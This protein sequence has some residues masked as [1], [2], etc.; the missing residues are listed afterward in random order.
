MSIRFYDFNG[1]SVLIKNPLI[2]T[3]WKEDLLEYTAGDTIENYFEIENISGATISNFKI[4]VHPDISIWYFNNFVTLLSNL[5]M[6]AKIIAINRIFDTYFEILMVKS[7]KVIDVRGE[8]DRIIIISQNT[9]QDQILDGL[10]LYFSSGII[11]G[12]NFGFM[13]SK[14]H[15]N[16]KI[17]KDLFGLPETYYKT[18]DYNIFANGTKIK[19]WI[20]VTLPSDWDSHEN[21]F[22]V[23]LDTFKDNNISLDNDLRYC[24]RNIFS[25]FWIPFHANVLNLSINDLPFTIGG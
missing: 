3:T 17:A 23:K 18:L 5:P 22:M 14:G 15:F 9:M 21:P 24:I 7:D 12:D 25:N 8:Q 6:Q 10:R 11:E 2:N 1:G 19:I 13:L 16:T 20:K 4:A